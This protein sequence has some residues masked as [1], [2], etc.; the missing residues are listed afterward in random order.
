M[1]H[2][3]TYLSEV[4]NAGLELNVLAEITQVILQEIKRNLTNF[5]SL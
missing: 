4:E 1:R 2:L 5:Y 3:P